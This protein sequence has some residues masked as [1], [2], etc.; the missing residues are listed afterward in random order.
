MKTLIALSI[1]GLV[2]STG[3]MAAAADAVRAEVHDRSGTTVGEV[4]ATGTPSGRVILSIAL[5]DL[6]PGLHGVHIH[7]TGDCSAEDF[8][9]AGGHLAGD[10]SHGV[11]SEDGPHPGDL[12]NLTVAADGSATVEYF[13]PDLDIDRDLLDADGAAFIVH[14]GSDDYSSQPSGNAG[15]RIACGVFAAE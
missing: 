9:S 5:S 1:A 8:T 12:P 13:S 2:A 15:E 10:A 3:T 6:P 4:T 14:S 11:L 7:E